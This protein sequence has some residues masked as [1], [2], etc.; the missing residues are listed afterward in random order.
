MQVTRAMRFSE[1][2]IEQ[3]RQAND[4]VS[5]IS[6]YVA[7]KRRGGNFWACCP[8]H[9][10]KTAS[11]S[12]AAEKGFFYCFGCHASGNVFT[13]IMKKENISFSEAVQRLAER[14]H[15]PLPV[16]E[17]TEEEKQRDRLRERLFAI[18]EMA[19]NF[20]HNCL[21]KTHYG[22]NG[23]AYLHRRGLNDET[24]HEFRLGFAPDSW[25]KL[26]DAFIR[27]HV[28]PEE[29]LRL[30]LIKEKKGHYYDA[31]RNR[32]IFPIFDGRDRVVGFGGRVLDDSK[33][34][35]LNSPET[36]VFNKRKLLFAMN[37]A[38]RSIYSEGRAVLVEGYMDVVSAHNKGITNVV[39]SLGT[40]FTADQARLLQRQAKEIILAYDMDDAGRQATVRAMEIVRSL[41]MK[42]RVLTLGD[43]K[44]PDEY[45]TAHGPEAFKEALAGAPNVLDY[46]LLTGLRRYDVSTLE[47][48]SAVT[49]AVMPVLIRVD[50]PIIVEAFMKKMAERLQIDENAV[51]SEYNTYVRRHPEAGGRQVVISRDVAKLNAAA[52][53]GNAMAVAEENILRYLLERPAAYG[54]VQKKIEAAYFTDPKRRAVYE[55]IERQY[56]SGGQ[57]TAAAVQ[58]AL[59]PDIRNEAARILVLEDVPLDEQVLVD[60]VMRFRLAVLQAD[61][62]K[63]SELAAAYSLHDDPRL[64]DALAACKNLSNE[65]KQLVL[66]TKKGAHDNGN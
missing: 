50:S 25:N 29:L 22:E 58:D 38:H 44:D 61:Y 63:H 28:P 14:A 31:F 7:L 36:P 52:R 2:F 8:F 54:R 30:G 65:I 45:I 6:D 43:G 55:E 18:N 42:I 60:Y 33:P 5:V 27:K 32:V 35:Y 26:A 53:G 15:I 40:A 64:K 1:E 49:A 21:V 24:I 51:R 19:C 17:K 48:K 23:L 66:S 62:K 41:G 9:S 57:Y 10:E 37:R 56:T 16:T 34:K 3:V 13:F 47:G 59:P 39:A 12:V 46:M 4:I 11:F 20:F